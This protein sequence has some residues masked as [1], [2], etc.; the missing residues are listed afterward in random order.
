MTFEVFPERP[1]D[2]HGETAFT[3]TMGP[4][5]TGTQ[6]RDGVEPPI[7]KL[8]GGDGKTD[9]KQTFPYA[10]GEGGEQTPPHNHT[11]DP[12]EVAIGRSADNRAFNP[13]D[14]TFD[15]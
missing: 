5:N 12:R 8:C 4:D 10:G 14:R 3:E 11:K 15:F 13:I 7:E 1:F 6:Q 9:F 2:G